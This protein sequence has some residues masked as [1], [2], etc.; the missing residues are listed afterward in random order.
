MKITEKRIESDINFWD[1]AEGEVFVYEAEFYMKLCGEYESADESGCN[2]VHMTT[3]ELS[4]FD[5]WEQVVRPLKV[6]PMEVH[7]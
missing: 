5:D 7:W 2:A 4:H 1:I 3:G 6:I